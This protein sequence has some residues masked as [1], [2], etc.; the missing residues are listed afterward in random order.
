MVRDTLIN[1]QLDVREFV[2]NDEKYENLPEWRSSA[3]CLSD[4]FN[5]IQLKLWLTLLQLL[6]HCFL[7][8]NF[9][10]CLT[11]EKAFSIGMTWN[12]MKLTQQA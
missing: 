11:R 7:V 3:H 8:D 10:K 2:N 9:L 5:S 4:M 12:A 6:A 1:E